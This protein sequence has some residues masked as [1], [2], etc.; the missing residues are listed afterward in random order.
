MHVE[1]DR[2]QTEERILADELAVFEEKFNVNGDIVCDVMKNKSDHVI[3][4][5][6][7]DISNKAVI[8]NIDRQVRGLVEQWELI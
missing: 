6:D 3:A 5:L 1:Y 8:G 2:L 4:N 7:K